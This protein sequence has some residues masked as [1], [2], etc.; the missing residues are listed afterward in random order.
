MLELQKQSVSLK[1]LNLLM[2]VSHRIVLHTKVDKHSPQ[3]LVSQLLF[4]RVVSWDLV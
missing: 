3:R 4:L 1:I 2:L